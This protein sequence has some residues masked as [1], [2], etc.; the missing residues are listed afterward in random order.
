MDSPVLLH[1]APLGET[2]AAEFTGEGTVASV[3]PQVTLQV[4]LLGEPETDQDCFM[5]RDQILL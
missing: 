2:L 4:G 1:V 3:E 5:F